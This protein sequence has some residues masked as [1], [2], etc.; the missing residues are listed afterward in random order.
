MLYLNVS[1]WQW[2]PVVHAGCIQF[3]SEV[4][5]VLTYETVKRKG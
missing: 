1:I 3:L 2:L 4:S 5:F